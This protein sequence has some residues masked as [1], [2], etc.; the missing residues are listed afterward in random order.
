M[1]AAIHEAEMRIRSRGEPSKFKPKRPI[2]MNCPPCECTMKSADQP[3]SNSK[4]GG[5]GES[6][7]EFGLVG[8]IWEAATRERRS[9]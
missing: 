8:A 9:L 5:G 4:T 6:A 2:C 7:R 1:A 3:E